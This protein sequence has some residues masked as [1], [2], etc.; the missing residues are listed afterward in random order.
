MKNT[1]S[2][3][4][5]YVVIAALLVAALVGVTVF[6]AIP[7]ETPPQ[8]Y[9]DSQAF[10]DDVCVRYSIEVTDA[11]NNYIVSFQNNLFKAILSFFGIES[12]GISLSGHL[13]AELITEFYLNA[14][15][16]GEKLVRLGEVL[17]SFTPNELCSAGVDTLMFFI[18][19][20]PITEEQA[21]ETYVE[22]SNCGELEEGQYSERDGA[23][24][25]DGEVVYTC[26]K[27]SAEERES[28]VER[29]LR[30]L[31]S[32]GYYCTGCSEYLWI[33][34]RT[35]SDE[36]GFSCKKCGSTVEK[37]TVVV[38]YSSIETM[39]A[40]FA[41]SDPWGT[42][43]SF[44]EKTMLSTEETARLLYQAVYLLRNEEQ[45]KIMDEFGRQR[46]SDL[47]VAIVTVSEGISAF[48]EGAGSLIEARAL[49]SLAYEAGAMLDGII[50]DIGADK[51]L[52]AFGLKG[53][54]TENQLTEFFKEQG[55]D[56]DTIA[57][58]DEFNAVMSAAD[59]VIEFLLHFAAGALL[60]SDT[61]LFDSVY[62]ASVATSEQESAIHRDFY[63][64]EIARCL[65]RG[66]DRALGAGT[67]IDSDE[68]A[69][70]KIASV[71]EK[72]SLLEEK[73]ESVSEEEL[74]QLFNRARA[75][76]ALEA[77]SPEE[78]A[79][80]DAESRAKVTAFIE[81]SEALVESGK[82]S[83]GLEIF[84]TSFVA[85]VV[86]DALSAAYEQVK[87]QPSIQ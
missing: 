81:C 70:E 40:R 22:C 23:D 34:E 51:F 73:D 68:D 26:I 65:T 60:A 25:A 50:G 42:W 30:Y 86:F 87:Q 21:E 85:N 19:I 58:A 35:G 57:E 83:S 52:N 75:L 39:A 31:S 71:F 7:R 80:S 43:Q 3:R 18:D 59:E 20:T 54:H 44:A 64:L 45:Q 61:P 72:L 2:R 29:K 82:L 14:G 37:R 5:I 33:N 12:E 27:C 74:M 28:D 76:S 66:L 6:V 78:L 16:P 53:Y 4:R 1:S 47:V 32:F 24:G 9:I 11:F 67:E 15:I 56:A 17:A 38:S 63:A 13:I 79:A 69:A 36:E 62:Y 10:S 49:A 84:G 77:S 48:A 8:G 55:V 46:F 41:A